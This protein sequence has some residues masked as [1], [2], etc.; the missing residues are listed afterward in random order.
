M[1]YGAVENPVLLT[2]VNPGRPRRKKEST[3]MAKAKK[4]R[5]RAKK[6]TRRMRGW[7][8]NAPMT[9][10]QR[11]E[12]LAK[13]REKGKAKRAELAAAQAAWEAQVG[14][15]PAA[16]E[17]RLKK[18]KREKAAAKRGVR[19]GAA[20]GKKL[21][22]EVK[23]LGKKQAEI[24]RI[25]GTLLKTSKKDRG[26]AR[27]AAAF[28][29]RSDASALIKPMMKLLAVPKGARRAVVLPG[30]EKSLR[31]ALSPIIRSALRGELRATQAERVGK[32]GRRE[33]RAMSSAAKATTQK[34]IKEQIEKGV[35]KMGS[36][37]KG[38]PTRD[39]W[40]AQM[41][42]YAGP[43]VAK[44]GGPLAGLDKRKHLVA[45]DAWRPYW[46]GKGVPGW[47]WTPARPGKLSYRKNPKSRGILGKIK[48]FFSIKG[49]SRKGRKNPAGE[50]AKN[51]LAG[52]GAFIL[53]RLMGN[54]ANRS[55]WFGGYERYAPVGASLVN[56]LVVNMAADRVKGLTPYKT[57]LL[58]GAGIQLVETAIDAFAP[59][60][61]NSLFDRPG[62]LGADLNVYEAAL[63]DD[64]G[65]SDYDLG[66]SDE[67]LLAAAAGMGEYVQ[68][69]E[70]L[71]PA[72]EDMSDDLGE[73]VEMGEYVA[74]SDDELAADDEANDEIDQL[75]G[76]DELAD[77]VLA[78][79][80]LADDMGDDMGDDLGAEPAPPPPFA[81]S[82]PAPKPAIRRR[83]LTPAVRK[84]KVLARRTGHP[85]GA[86]KG[87][88]LTGTQ[89]GG[90]FG[91]MAA[92]PKATVAAPQIRVAVKQIAAATPGVV[93]T[94]AHFAAVHANVQKA[95]GAP[96]PA[97]ATLVAYRAETVGPQAALSAARKARR[98]LTARGPKARVIVRRGTGGMI[99]VSRPTTKRALVQ[100]KVR[101]VFAKPLKED[102]Q[103]IFKGD[104]FAP[105]R[106]T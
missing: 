94:P 26:G 93:G 70:Y 105:G 91:T 6:T 92:A 98:A 103:G 35:A 36:G 37:R 96:V 7:R 4:S 87:R 23:E 77:E 68:M 97:P 44:P 54:L 9:P 64:L 74:M 10:E 13:G 8:S 11:L 48:S 28:M 47:H 61:L 22:A 89:T 67:E 88:V 18:E 40:M 15:S 73:Y 31:K 33:S 45:L 24:K 66:A 50:I 75:V 106:D 55:G 100:P 95:V 20:A 25:L 52:T 51:A 27:R 46:P 90:I 42:G 29:Q 12:A 78:D 76:E 59:P 2:L 30:M 38:R 1:R 82:A 83:K 16:R 79:E 102:E 49:A 41:A 85:A 63:Q 53:G 3:S 101:S 84:A 43:Y 62:G 72:D 65:Y 86:A 56:V 57:A 32:R 5:K 17:R 104:I 99:E 81:D 34:W 58:T 60:K 39:E 69:G 14:E 71:L 21:T 19:A 80:V